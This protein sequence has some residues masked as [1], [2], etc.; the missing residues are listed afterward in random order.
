MSQLE[1]QLHEGV[2]AGSAFLDQPFTESTEQKRTEIHVAGQEVRAAQ[3]SLYDF[4]TLGKKGEKLSLNG[5]ENTDTYSE[6]KSKLAFSTGNRL[7]AWKYTHHFFFSVFPN[8][9]NLRAAMS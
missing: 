8:L 3:G 9:S 6:E 5:R 7:A 4:L 1:G 2:R